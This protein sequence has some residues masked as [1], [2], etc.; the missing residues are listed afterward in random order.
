MKTIGLCSQVRL[1]TT[2]AL[3]L[4]LGG[5]G[6]RPK[7]PASA[8]EPAAVKTTRADGTTVYEVKVGDRI[9]Q[10]PEELAGP[11]GSFN[12]DTVIWFLGW[13]GPQ[14]VRGYGQPDLR[15]FIHLVV[16]GMPAPAGPGFGR[17]HFASTIEAGNYGAP[18]FNAELG[19]MEYRQKG[20]PGW[21]LY[22]SPDP[23]YV[24]VN[25]FAPYAMCNPTPS[26]FWDNT[27]ECRVDQFISPRIKYY[28]TFSDA[29]L[30]QW[31]K[32]DAGIRD[33]L[34]SMTAPAR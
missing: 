31:P 30:P 2:V 28:Y 21:T 22:S 24:G 6:E 27:R 1:A 12:T 19:L 20:P 34:M 23:S 3:V 32:I 33:F 29:L 25:G 7:L 26:K 15:H 5:C 4:C 16:G 13:P 17:N 11:T 9:F 18:T 10:I 14:V 8:T